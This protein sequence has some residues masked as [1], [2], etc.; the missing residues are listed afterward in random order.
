MSRES[1]ELAG[2]VL[3]AIT[4]RDLSRLI[5]LTDPDVEWQSFF[6]L[7][8][9]GGVYRG[10]DGIRQ[11][12]S[13]LYDAWEIVRPEANERLGVGEVAVLIGRVHYRGKASGVETE[14][15]AGWV[16]K[17]RNGR[18]QLFRAF[19]EPE[20]TLETLGLYE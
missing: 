20:Q 6:A 10:H 5:A 3:E 8:E 7:G 4:R 19:Q 12:V 9:A 14:S 17:F 2:E 11:Y 13:D 15:P 18:V 1:V 16:F